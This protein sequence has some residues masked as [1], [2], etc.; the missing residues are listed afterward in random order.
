MSIRA[1]Q[2]A[3]DLKVLDVSE[4][5]ELA[6]ALLLDLDG[7]A[8][9]DAEPAWQAEVEHRYQEYQSNKVES[10]QGKEAMERIR[11]KLE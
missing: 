5:A 4:R 10:V 1:K 2:L 9:E 7:K 11:S 3:T 6:Y 8:D